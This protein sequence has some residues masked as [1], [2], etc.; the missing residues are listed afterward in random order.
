MKNDRT[1]G[2]EHHRADHR[3]GPDIAD[4][5]HDVGEAPDGALDRG[6]LAPEVATVGRA[7][8]PHDERQVETRR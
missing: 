7:H 3:H 1:A 8:Q 4:G 5:L 2:Q 6:L